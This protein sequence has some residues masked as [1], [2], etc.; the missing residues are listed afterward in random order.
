MY[1]K[2]TCWLL[3]LK[4]VINGLHFYNNYSTLL[5]MI[6]HKTI[7]VDFLD[8]SNG[9]TIYKN[10]DM[11]FQTLNTGV[12]QIIVK[13]SV[14]LLIISIVCQTCLSQEWKLC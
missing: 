8:C 10:D 2:S 9:K 3:V 7:I 13:T 12:V 1:T 11:Y 5:F 6:Y 4:R 14:G